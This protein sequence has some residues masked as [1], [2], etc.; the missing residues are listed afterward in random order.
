MAMQVLMSLADGGMD[1][2]IH[3][4]RANYAEERMERAKS[5]LRPDGDER[6]P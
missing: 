1:E 6:F 2:G 3:C 4:N 5:L